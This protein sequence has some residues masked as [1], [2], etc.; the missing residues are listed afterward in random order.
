[1]FFSLILQ[2]FLCRQKS[3]FRT[4][5]LLVPFERIRVELAKESSVFGSDDRFRDSVIVEINDGRTCRMPGEFAFAQFAAG[6]ECPFAVNFADLSVQYRIEAVEEKIVLAVAIP[7]RDAEL[8][9]A[10]FAGDAIGPHQWA[11]VDL[12]QEYALRML[13][14]KIPRRFSESFEPC[15]ISFV[16]KHDQIRK[17]ILVPIVHQRT[18]APLRQQLLSFGLFPPPGQLRRRAVPLDLYRLH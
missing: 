4:C 10:A 5:P 1:M 9:A 7:I 8:A 17:S 12:A 16:I 11:H 6:G 3:R 13:E 14:R 2:I 15:E 18:G